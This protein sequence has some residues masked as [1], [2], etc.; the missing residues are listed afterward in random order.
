MLVN[1]GL[2]RPDDADVVLVSASSDAGRQNPHF[3]RPSNGAANWYLIESVGS[4]NDMVVAID[5]D[6]ADPFRLY[7]GTEGGSI[8]CSEVR[9]ESCKPISIKMPTIAVSAMVVA[10][11]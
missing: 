5:W 6:P 3:C 1:N 4:D 2:Q 10:P 11:A 8:F 9:G 7:A